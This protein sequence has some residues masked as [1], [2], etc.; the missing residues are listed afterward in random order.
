MWLI[1]KIKIFYIRFKKMD[2]L[3]MNINKGAKKK[4]DLDNK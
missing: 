4:K 3:Y 1:E 2:N